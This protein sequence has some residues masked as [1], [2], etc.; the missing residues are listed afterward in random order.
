MTGN[1][2]LDDVIVFAVYLVVIAAFLILLKRSLGIT[3]DLQALLRELKDLL[4]VRVTPEALDGISI[5][6][7]TV[8][9]LLVVIGLLVAPWREAALWLLGR[10]EGTP[11]PTLAMI[12]VLFGFWVLAMVVSQVVC[13]AYRNRDWS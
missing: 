8:L 11:V 9:E 5:I 10:E 13:V 6:L 3:L 1:H 7:I 4:T 2:R 12:G